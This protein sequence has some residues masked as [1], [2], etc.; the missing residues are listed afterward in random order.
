MD[1]TVYSCEEPDKYPEL[2]FGCIEKHENKYCVQLFNKH[3]N[4]DLLFATPVVSLGSDV[5]SANPPS[6]LLVRCNDDLET[7]I[8][9]YRQIC[10]D[11][12]VEQKKTWFS[13]D[14]DTAM[15]QD[16]WK[17][18]IKKNKTI[19]FKVSS[20]EE[21]PFTHYGSD[22]APTT[23][24]LHKDTDVKLLVR[25]EALWF[26]RSNFGATYTVLQLMDASAIQE[27]PK[28]VRHVVTE[29]MI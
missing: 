2:E 1:I 6:E 26:S 10:L 25:L 7:L 20:R 27:A 29:K 22:G 14:F 24:V 28:R 3:D 19:K 17:D 15:L 4:D 21:E 11:E 12:A 9:H 16:L 8:H 18:N 23:A 13:R 5:D